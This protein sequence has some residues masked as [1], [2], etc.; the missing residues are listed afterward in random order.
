MSRIANELRFAVC[1]V[2]KSGWRQFG[3]SHDVIGIKIEIDHKP[4]TI[5]G[6]MPPG[7]AFPNSSMIGLGMGLVAAVWLAR[8]LGHFLYDVWP[9]DPLTLATVCTLLIAVAA[10]ASYVPARAASRID[11]SEALRYE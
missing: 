5:V 8:L 10:V 9:A 2:R 7:F 6:I 1:L 4:A 11:P 3:G